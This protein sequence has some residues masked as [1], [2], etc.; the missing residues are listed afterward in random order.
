MLSY[1][2]IYKKERKKT[3]FFFFLHNPSQA[4]QSKWR[5]KWKGKKKNFFNGFGQMKKFRVNSGEAEHQKY[6]Q[7]KNKEKKKYI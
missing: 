5:T 7:R 2:Y 4:R 3:L 1:V 6:T